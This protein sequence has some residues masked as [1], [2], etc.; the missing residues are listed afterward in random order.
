MEMDSIPSIG[1]EL[2]SK[3]SVLAVDDL[4]AN[5][6]S[7]EQVLNSDEVEVVSA[8]SGAEALRKILKA[9]YC[10][11]LLDIRMPGMDGFEVAQIIRADP[12]FAQTPIIF[13]TAEAKDQEAVF[14]GYESGAVDFLIKP[15]S[16]QVIRAKVRVFADLYRQRKAL[17]KSQLIAKLYGQLK[18]SNEELKQYTTIASHDMREPLRRIHCLVDLLKIE[19]EELSN[20]EINEICDDLMRCTVEG[21]ALVDDFR[22]LTQIVNA[23]CDL[24]PSSLSDILT[25][26][27]EAKREEIEK[28]GI[29]VKIDASPIVNANADLVKELFRSLIDNALVHTGEQTIDIEFASERK[30]DTGEWVFTVYN[31]GSSIDESKR[32]TIFKP[33]ARLASYQKWQHLGLGLTKAKKIVER[34]HGR[35][36]VESLKNGVSFRF[37]LPGKKN[38]KIAK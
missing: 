5:L 16:P 15:L 13:V 20:T 8:L 9:E 1:Q 6:I 14:Q 10:C 33:F 19:A 24:A 4:K 37:T 34:H 35:I 38:D 36:W 31:S 32:E 17:D 18:E 21:L 29:R 30:S 25:T 7:L 11:I 27:V 23:D 12:V 26:I 3:V 28:R 22:E 2:K